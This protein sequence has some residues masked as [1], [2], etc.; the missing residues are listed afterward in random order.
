MWGKTRLRPGNPC[1]A[2]REIGLTEDKDVPQSS[3]NKVSGK[4]KTS[5]ISRHS[6]LLAALIGVWTA[7]MTEGQ[8]LTTVWFGESPAIALGGRASIF[9]HKRTNPKTDS[10]VSLTP[11]PANQKRRPHSAPYLS[12]DT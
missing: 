11:D 5:L 2:R 8:S 9:P 10:A 6:T 3:C 1:L 4:H 12:Y 7:M